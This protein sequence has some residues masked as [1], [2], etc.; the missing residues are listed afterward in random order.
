MMAR[1]L[2]LFVLILGLTL[3]SGCT[4]YQSIGKSVGPFVHPVTGQDFVHIP[5]EEWNTSKNALFYFYRP[6]SEWASQE[7]E[8]PSVYIDD[9]HYFNIRANSY[10]WMEVYPGTR[11][12]DIRR[13][14]LGLEGV[15]SHL[16]SLDLSRIADADVTVEP[17]HVYYFRYS[18]ESEPEKVH[19]MLAPDDPLASG[20]L[21]LVPR[22]VAIQEIVD[23]QFLNSDMLAPNHAATSIVEVNREH[24]YEAEMARLE[25]ER[26]KELERLKEE[27][28]YESPPWYWPFGGGPT[29]T[30]ESDKKIQE[31]Q[32]KREAYL[33]EKERR[34][35]AAEGDSGWWPF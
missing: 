2:Q 32:A 27:G 24:D 25:E 8:S 30:L 20:T 12:I 18:E 17:G 34:E 9:H 5:N 22:D 21:T 10:T 3:F 11:H 6:N 1:F 19:P 26:E 4:V 31:L 28:K 14:L 33:E 29:V 15:E 13:P 7:I 16:L 23:T 35:E